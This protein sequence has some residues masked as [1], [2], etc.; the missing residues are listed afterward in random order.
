MRETSKAEKFSPSCLQFGA[1]LR[2][3]RMEPMETVETVAT[4]ELTRDN[5]FPVVE[6][7]CWVAN[8]RWALNFWLTFETLLWIFFFI[9]ALYYEIVLVDED[10]L[11]RFIDEIDDW[12]FYLLFGDRFSY[13]DQRIRSE[14]CERRSFIGMRSIMDSLSS[15]HHSHQLLVDA[16]FLHVRN[17]CRHPNLWNQFG[18]S[19]SC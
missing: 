5:D 1:E 18:E 3:E 8:L 2:C 15:L 9:V 13:L 17:L 7:C 11:M 6:K 4:V 16:D 14:W 19:A 12:Y 10:D